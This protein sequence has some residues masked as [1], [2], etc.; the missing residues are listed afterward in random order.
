MARIKKEKCI[1]YDDERKCYYVTKTAG[2]SKSYQTAKTLA[3]AKQILKD[4][5]RQKAQGKVLPTRPDTL[6]SKIEEYISY[7]E[8]TLAPATIYGY[9]ASLSNHISP[10]FKKK[11]IQ[12]VTVSDLKN[13]TSAMSKK[14]LSNTTIRKHL[15]LLNAVFKAAKREKIILDTPFDLFDKIPSDTKEKDCYNASEIATLLATVRDTPLETPVFLAVY[16]GLRRG[17][18]DGL[19]WEHVDLEKKIISISSSRTQ[20]GD[21]IIE[22]KPKTEKSN[23]KLGIPDP[24]YDVLLRAKDRNPT[25]ISLSSPVPH[26]DYVVKMKNGKPFR[27]GYISDA[28]A[29]HLKKYKLRPITFH[30]LRHSYTSI[31]VQAGASIQE[32]SSSLGHANIGVTTT[33]YTHEFDTVKTE[34]ANAVAASIAA[35]QKNPDL[36][37]L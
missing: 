2:G 9:R 13:Y 25:S 1:S 7:K 24:L 29:N 5:K 31:A 36:S 19:K 8:R 14:G 12:D 23:R 18:I 10:Y 22:K 3:E 21:Q 30:T 16:L 35:A 34:A 27:P 6:V 4:H 26:N 11:K 17:E 28:F 20:V 32:I 37:H 15:D 33:I